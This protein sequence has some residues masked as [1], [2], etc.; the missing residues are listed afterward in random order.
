[1]LT[2][3]PDDN[4]RWWVESSYAM[5]QGMNSHTGNY[6]K[7]GKGTMYRSSCKQELKT[8]IATD[9]KLIG[10]DDVMEIAFPCR[11]RHICANH[12]HISRQQN[13]ILRS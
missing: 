1:M 12:C 5:Q 13:K 11:T 6:M 10:I 4:P 7:I 8:K 9:A 3:E 2:V